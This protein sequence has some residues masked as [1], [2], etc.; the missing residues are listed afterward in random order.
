MNDFQK[1]C[2]YSGFEFKKDHFLSQ[3]GENMLQY[4]DTIRL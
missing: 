3:S 4:T 1:L 2:I